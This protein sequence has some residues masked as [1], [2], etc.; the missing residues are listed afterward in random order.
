MAK[1]IPLDKDLTSGTVYRCESDKYYVIEAI[2][3][4]STNEPS[5]VDIDAKR[6]AE[7]A[8]TTCPMFVTE[9]NL[10]GPLPLGDL[11]LVV[12]PEKTIVFTGSSGSKL[13]IKGKMIILGAGET[14]DPVHKARFEVQH[15]K[16]VSFI[17]GKYTFSANTAVP[18][19]TK[20]TV[21]NW[22]CPVGE[23]WNFNRYIGVE[24]ITTD[25]A[26]KGDLAFEVFVEGVPQDL[27]ETTMGPK[28]FAAASA[29]YPPRNTKNQSVFPI[30]DLNLVFIPG[31]TLRIDATNVADLAAPGAGVSWEYHAILVGEKSLKTI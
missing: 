9:S 29:P 1:V 23:E 22:D 8:P 7:L 24:A 31:R 5:Y 21:I 6:V 20:Q 14:I 16:I 25:G 15:T 3:T 27:I 2:G 28:G 30:Q 11:Y 17:H 13:K 18:A 10:L 26:S 19:G 12:P 4:N